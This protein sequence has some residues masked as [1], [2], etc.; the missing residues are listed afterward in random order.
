MRPILALLV[1]CAAPAS[2]HAQ[3]YPSFDWVSP[4]PGYAGSQPL[5]DHAVHADGTVYVVANQGPTFYLSRY[6]PG[7]AVLW[8]VEHV[9]PGASAGQTTRVI[10]APDG[11]AYV[12]STVTAGS[13]VFLDL[14]VLKVTPEGAFAW[15][16]VR[17]GPMS[18]DWP[19]PPP[20]P[21]WGETDYVAD[22]AM[23]PN[24]HLVVAGTTGFGMSDYWTLMIAP[25]GA[26][27]WEHTYDAAPGSPVQ[28][29]AR[30]L[31]VDCDGQ[32]YVFGDVHRPGTNASDLVLL[33]ISP[34]GQ[35][36]RTARLNAD[37]N[38]PSRAVDVKA[39][40]GG[41]VYVTG[42]M[43]TA[44]PGAY[45][46]TAAYEPGEP[47]PVWTA[48]NSHGAVSVSST[49]AFLVLDGFGRLYVTGTVVLPEGNATHLVRYD[50][51]TGATLWSRTNV[52]STNQ[53]TVY[54]AG[55]ATDEAGVY[56]A[57]HTPTVPWEM[58]IRHYSPEGELEWGGTFG[59][60]A[61]L[62]GGVTAP[63]FGADNAIGRHGVGGLVARVLHPASGLS[64]AR[65]RVAAEPSAEVQI[66]HASAALAA[67]GPVEI[68]LNQSP[69]STTPDAVVSFRSGTAMLPVPS[70]QPI[71]VRARLQTPPPLPQEL[72]FM[73]PP[74]PPG[75]YVVSLAGIPS[76]VIAFYAPNPN[77]QPR[78]LSLVVAPLGD[79]TATRGGTVE[80]VATHAV[81]DAPALRVVVVETGQ[82]LADGFLY[83]QA[84]PAVTLAPGTYRI[85]AR[86]SV[87][88]ALLTAVR[89]VLD[90][91][92]STFA[93]ALT[94]FL[95]PASN[96][97]GPPLAL[98]A[99]DATGT[100][101]G[102]V[103]VTG[104]DGVIENDLML[105]LESPA[106]G[107]AAVRFSLGA[108]AHVRL[109]LVDAL[110]REVTRLADAPHAA[111]AHAATLDART[112][113][114]GVYALRLHAGEATVTR[115]LTLV[116]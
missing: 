23:H 33:Q 19:G 3:T 21:N 17:D 14:Y 115:R 97:N 104:G 61:S 1:L 45:W 92:E 5:Q 55:L 16:I 47:A 27:A 64:L 20:G 105:A 54:P 68:Y 56:V 114:P 74:L 30:A 63:R 82:V 40:C 76:E 48:T 87:D 57:D 59:M 46:R 36:V 25:G 43:P 79:A 94:G 18:G 42:Q 88:G 75:R 31:S 107:A 50:T 80:V 51:V 116:R 15:E 11:A 24:G 99:T 22:A 65:F 34:E 103:V 58:Q 112:L 67:L 83:G 95:D 110:G 4:V 6:S 73:A 96:Q 26:I 9:A 44:G 29:V 62:R 41:R 90:G 35:T 100:T 8:T 72:T 101:D 111:G 84:T 52:Y 38:A 89:F 86:R 109:V 49:P 10:V 113:A 53:P 93:L 66:V 12:V 71:S 32:I 39:E 77:G 28:D 7:G 78:D 2:L 85:E 60:Q 37:A 69:T 91:T 102:G 70:N 98:T 13:S 81:T 108:P 106:H